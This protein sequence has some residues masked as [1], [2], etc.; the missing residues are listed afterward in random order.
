MKKFMILLAFGFLLNSVRTIQFELEAISVNPAGIKL[1]ESGVTHNILVT[2]QNEI[3]SFGNRFRGNLGDGS[4]DDNVAGFSR[5]TELGE[6]ANREPADEITSVKVGSNLSYI[7]TASG[8][9]FMTGL[10]N[11]GNFGDGTLNDALLPTLMNNFGALSTIEVDDKIIQ[12]ETSVAGF[13]LSHVLTAKGRIFGWGTNGYYGGV[14]NDATTVVSLPVEITNNGEFTTLADGEKVIQIKNTRG[15]LFALTNQYRVFAW[16]YNYNNSVIPF[17]LP[18][19]GEAKLPKLLSTSRGIFGSFETNNEYITELLGG[20]FTSAFRTNLGNIVFT[21]IT[22]YTWVTEPIYLEN[23]PNFTLLNPNEKFIDFYPSNEGFFAITN[24][25]RLFA[26]GRN[27]SGVG[28][29]GTG[30]ATRAITPVDI[31]SNGALAD[32]DVSSI[33]HMTS[34]STTFALTEDGS[35]FG[36][37]ANSKG[38]YIGDTTI[39][40]V[41]LPLNLNLVYKQQVINSLYTPDEL[42][43]LQIQNLPD[44][45]DLNL[46]DELS[47]E[48]IRDNYEALTTEEKALVTNYQTLL[49]AEA[50]I[51]LLKQQAIDQAA[52][53]EVIALINALPSLENLTLEDEDQVEAARAAYDSLTADQQALVNNYQQQLDAENQITLLRQQAIDQAAAD[54]VIALINALPSVDDLTTSDAEA[55]LNARE[56][57]NALTSNQKDLVTNESTLALIEARLSELNSALPELNFILWLIILLILFGISGYAYWFFFKNKKQLRKEIL[58]K[59]SIVEAKSKPSI[60]EEIPTVNKIV[61]GDV[62]IGRDIKLATQFTAFSNVAP[63]SYLEIT[64]EFTSTNRVV[65]VRNSLPKVLNELNRFV[66]LSKEEVNLVKLSIP[67]GASFVKKTPGSFIDHEGYYVEIDL[68]NQF[69]DNYIFAKTRLAPTTTKGHRWVRIEPRRIRKA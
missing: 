47:I 49:D 63:G 53:D 18:V 38:E 55:V 68:N 25:N 60:K 29:L 6:L 9:L 13:G 28:Y 4:T 24:Q 66:A 34:F 39:T 43:V 56:A 2:N 36:W 46:E 67:S 21:G 17:P 31:T 35:L 42:V 64:P 69:V 37:G 7:L 61:L 57:Y 65:E 32:I 10:N 11:A 33:K 52:A 41:N 54:E 59:K 30:N 8:K 16:G 12:V 23:F 44:I 62:I 22:A 50:Q 14:G 20:S 3:F 1:I 5:I 51:A 48:D 15:A 58:K 26:Q 45:N 19:V 40:G 27:D